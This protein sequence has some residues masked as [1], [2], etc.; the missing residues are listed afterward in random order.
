MAT[1][2]VG[3]LFGITPEMYQQQMAQQGLAEGAKLGQM[4]PDEFGRAMLYAGAAQLGRGIG[5][6]LGA[7]DPQLRIISARNAVMREIDPNNPISLQN[8]IQRLS[9]AGD[10]AGALQLSDYLRKA[11]SDYALIQQRTAEKMTPEQRNALAYAASTGATQGSPEFGQAYQKKLSELISKTETT[12]PEMK[13]AAAVAAASFPIG[14]QEYKELYKNELARLTTKGEKQNIKEVGVAAGTREA[15][16]IDV[17]NDQQFVYQKGADG[18]QIRVPYFG[19]IDRVTSTTKIDVDKGETEFTKR[20][21]VKDADRVDAAMSMRESSAAA[22]RSLNRLN[23]LDQ[24]ALISGSFANGR[25]GATNFLNT[26]GLTSAKDQDSLAKSEN[27]QK[28]AGDVILATLGGKLGAG[29]SNED[30][31]FIQSLVPQL[32]NSPQARKQLIEFMV[33]KNQ[34]IVEET[35][36]LENYARDKKG[37]KGFVPTIPLFSGQQPTPSNAL[38]SMSTEQLQQM[39]KNAK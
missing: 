8:A 31:R 39:L 16:Y 15:V 9:S 28:T 3:G 34:E 4:A 1:D 38:Q 21:G 36:R 10:Q 6:A 24:N 5:G 37:L 11:Q 25:V 18:K 29:F 33:K 2:I 32:E 30:R 35:T 7:E 19:G 27:Y 26:L 12:T 22:L 13:N 14:S 20:L 17:N 23:Q